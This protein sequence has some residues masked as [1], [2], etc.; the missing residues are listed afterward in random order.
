MSLLLQIERQLQFALELS[1]LIAALHGQQHAIVILI[2]DAAIR[3]DAQPV[4]AEAALLPLC[5]GKALENRQILLESR[6][7][8]LKRLD[9]TRQ[10]LLGSEFD[11]QFALAGVRQAA[12]T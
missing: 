6:I 9:L 4:N 1:Y 5:R 3:F 11:L 7:F 12:Q 10:L 8:L 2:G